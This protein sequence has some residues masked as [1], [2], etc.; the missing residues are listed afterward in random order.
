M[1]AVQLSPNACTCSLN[2]AHLQKLISIGLMITM[3]ALLLFL[4]SLVDN[5]LNTS[6]QFAAAAEKGCWAPP[7]RH[8]QQAER[9][10]CATLL[11]ACRATP[12]MLCSV[13]VPTI[14]KISV[15]AGESSQKGHKGD[16]MTARLRGKPERTGFVQPSEKK[17][18]KDLITVF[19]YLKAKITPFLQVVTWEIW[20]VM[21]TSNSWET[22]KWTQ[23]F[24][25]WEQSGQE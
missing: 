19:L 25:H 21:A 16:Q 8:H 24:S 18:W 6:E 7:R 23:E 12:G 17:A 10:H 11:S 13:L 20:E 5:K 9:N 4:W 1:N 3:V 22:S 14:Q 15:E 2:A